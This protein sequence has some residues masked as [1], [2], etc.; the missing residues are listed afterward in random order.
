MGLIAFCVCC[1]LISFQNCQKTPNINF[2][3]GSDFYSSSADS[4][5]RTFHINKNSLKKIFIP[6]VNKVA[7]EESH[8][9]TQSGGDFLAIKYEALKNLP[10]ETDHG[11]I[12]SLDPKTG[13]F[14]YEVQKNYEGEDSFQ[15]M[16]RQNVYVTDSE[17]AAKT[18]K[19]YLDADG[20]SYIESVESL[21]IKILIG[22]EKE[23]S[24]IQPE[25]LLKVTAQEVDS[26]A[27]D[28]PKNFDD[29]SYSGLDD[30]SPQFKWSHSFDENGSGINYYELSIGTTPGAT[31]VAA[32]VNVGYVN[33]ISLQG[34]LEE[35]RKYFTSLRSVDF[36]GLKSEPSKGDGWVYKG[37]GNIIYD[38]K[39]KARYWADKNFAKSCEE[40]RHPSADSKYSYVGADIG[41]GI[42]MIDP[43]GPSVGTLGQKSPFTVYCD[44][45]QDGGGWTLL[46]KAK[47]GS[48]TFNYDSDYW[49]DDKT[50][51][52]ASLNANLDQ[53]AKFD[54]FISVA[55]K[56][57]RGCV[58]ENCF[59]RDIPSQYESAL[60][61]MS[62]SH[63]VNGKRVYFEEKNK[64]AQMYGEI[65][66]T[67]IKLPWDEFLQFGERIYDD[68]DVLL[69][70]KVPV[71][72][73]GFNMG[74]GSFSAG[75]VPAVK[76]NSTSIAVRFGYLGKISSK[77][78][79]FGSGVGLGL[80]GVW[81]PVETNGFGAGVYCTS[82]DYANCPKGDNAGYMKSAG[83]TMWIR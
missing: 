30:Q 77:E 59:S 10:M 33:K 31:D 12:E 68:N 27:P 82:G 60:D 41:D 38:T 45:T 52:V 29:G 25:V 19:V 56:T 65:L 24:V 74:S 58:E 37:F 4:L 9:L 72:F 62:Y 16:K 26:I 81:D 63:M 40:Y 21:K 73:F 32:W 44:M 49:T 43:D 18:H 14:I 36:A 64:Y 22:G 83:G 78:T 79:N 28:A 76:N 8:L 66:P 50:L 69:V 34:N 53:D 6:A 51:G 54:S 13:H 70:Q 15:I 46:L 23:E 67:G 75:K 1:F 39:S 7:I 48:E 3:R 17:T 55:G 20:K 11:I 71:R 42:Y 80:G 61:L 5:N 57:L 35:G 47:A 2:D